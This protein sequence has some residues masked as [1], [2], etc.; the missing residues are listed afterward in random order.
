[1]VP[2]FQD[3]SVG[4]LALYF[5]GPVK[6]VKARTCT[7][8]PGGRGRTRPIFGHERAAEGLEP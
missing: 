1:M 6:P 7:S 8:S 3:W 2:F 5:S 4:T